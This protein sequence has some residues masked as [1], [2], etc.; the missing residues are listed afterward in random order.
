M[1][2]LIA[3]LVATLGLIGSAAA[4]AAAPST[5]AVLHGATRASA[6]RSSVGLRG[7]RPLRMSRA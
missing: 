3:I 6:L 7:S 4:A 1:K 5:I 2:L